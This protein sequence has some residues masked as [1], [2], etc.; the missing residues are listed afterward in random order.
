MSVLAAPS[1]DYSAEYLAQELQ[2]AEQ[3]LAALQNI[4]EHNSTSD[5]ADLPLGGEAM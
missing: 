2:S 3:A 5:T 1:A 4:D